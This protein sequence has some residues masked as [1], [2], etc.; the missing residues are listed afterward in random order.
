M[1]E[2]LQQAAATAAKT[3]EGT[4]TRRSGNGKFGESSKVIRMPDCF[5]AENDHDAEQSKCPEFS[6]GFKAWLYYAES[7]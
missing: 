2:Q 1:V 4:L 7:M 6:M 3:M 5:G